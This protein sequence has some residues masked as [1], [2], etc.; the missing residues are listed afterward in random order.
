MKNVEEIKLKDYCSNV[1]GILFSPKWRL[2]DKGKGLTIEKLDKLVISMKAMMDGIL[3]IWVEKE[4]I[5]DILE[6]FEK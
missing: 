3:F 2:G 6:V 5:M 1:Q 4:L